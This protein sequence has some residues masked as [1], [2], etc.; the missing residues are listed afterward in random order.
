MGVYG[1]SYTI[2]NA[3][4]LL[5]IFTT[6]QFHNYKVSKGA[7]NIYGLFNPEMRTESATGELSV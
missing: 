4:R 5:V 3:V 7:D 6:N 2:Y 1:Y